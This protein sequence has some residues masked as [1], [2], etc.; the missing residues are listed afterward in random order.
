MGEKITL[1]KA[2]DYVSGNAYIQPD[3]GK[4]YMKLTFEFENTSDNTLYVSSFNFEAYADGYAM[5]QQYMD[6]VNLD[7]SLSKGN[8][9][10]GTVLFEVPEDA[11]KIT[12][13]YMSNFWSD[14][15][16]KFI[17]K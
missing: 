11:E 15:K 6:G 16:V 12:V 13:E 10:K 8:Q 1:L 9:T 3:K 2:E 4:K 7:A 14:D 5:E 17:V